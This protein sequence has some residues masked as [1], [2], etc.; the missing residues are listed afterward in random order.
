[1][2]LLRKL[3]YL[4][5]CLPL[6]IF[7]LQG[8]FGLYG[9][10]KLT[11]GIDDKQRLNPKEIPINSRAYNV[12]CFWA[13]WHIAWAIKTLPYFKWTVEKIAPGYLLAELI[14]MLICINFYPHPEHG[15]RFSR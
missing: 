1:V 7:R 10:L 2:S 15:V 3:R 11:E 8:F 13:I 12:L 4:N 5:H 6:D 14:V 9:T